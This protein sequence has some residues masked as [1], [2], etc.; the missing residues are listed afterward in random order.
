M[1]RC[2]SR[3]HREHNFDNKN[4]LFMLDRKPFFS[5]KSGERG[6]FFT[7]RNSLSGGFDKILK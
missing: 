3:T 4:Q 2:R 5:G 6:K 7:Q 1:K